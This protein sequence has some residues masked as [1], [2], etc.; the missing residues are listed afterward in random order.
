MKGDDFY[1]ENFL[2]FFFVSIEIYSKSN[3]AC[4]LDF[5]GNKFLKFTVLNNRPW[6][7]SLLEKILTCL[8][9][10]K[11]DYVVI[12]LELLLSNIY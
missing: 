11:L 10:N 12:A 4:T 6:D 8:K 9:F 7:E 3:S 1:G 2:S 5:T